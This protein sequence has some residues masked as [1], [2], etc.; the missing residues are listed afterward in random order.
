M[1]DVA[2]QVVLSR[3]AVPPHLSA[4]LSWGAVTQ[5]YLDWMVL[6]SSA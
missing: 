3:N 4:A 5:D 1:G 2:V 6:A